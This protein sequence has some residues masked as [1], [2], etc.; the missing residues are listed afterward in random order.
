MINTLWWIK[1]AAEIGV[2][3]WI[4]P[5]V[6]PQFLKTIWR[7]KVDYSVSKQKD[8]LVMVPG[9]TCDVGTYEKFLKEFQD[10]YNILPLQNFP[11]WISAIT[12]PM[13]I[14]SRAHK[15]LESVE[16]AQNN[17]DI[18]GRLIWMWHSIW[19]VTI[20]YADSV[21]NQQK[22][23]QIQFDEIISLSW[24]INWS[25]E[26]QHIPIVAKLIKS[27]RDLSREWSVI[28]EIHDKWRIDHNFITLRD[29]ILEQDEM[30]FHR[31]DE[32][33]LDHGHFAYM[34]WTQKQRQETSQK[35]KFALAA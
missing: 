34:L 21:L 35:V 33:L 14:K 22:N 29:Q 18:T 19:G 3:M 6:I 28:R 11:E 4:S 10:E 16:M 8:T 7:D 30:E 9:L 23:T 20:V 2:N 15:V 5:R 25:K 12:T 13:S 24:P 17:W 32:I 1:R 27:V 31:W 26:L